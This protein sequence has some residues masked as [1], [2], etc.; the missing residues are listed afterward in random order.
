MQKTMPIYLD[1]ALAEA[2]LEGARNRK[3]EVMNR[4][5][6][7]LRYV[8]S[9]CKPL[10]GFPTFDYMIDLQRSKIKA[11]RSKISIMRWFPEG[12]G[13]E[14]VRYINIPTI[15]L[16]ESTADANITA[17]LE[18]WLAERELRRNERRAREQEQETKKKIQ[19]LISQ[20]A[21]LDPSLAEEIK[22]WK[23]VP[24]TKWEM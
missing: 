11:T 7:R 5:I 18:A 4:I 15:W 16:E 6:H 9:L 8:I 13:W 22:K 10:T 20:A 17:H 12:V 14:H 24:K 2:Q 19:N 3:A 23:I 1:L 21:A